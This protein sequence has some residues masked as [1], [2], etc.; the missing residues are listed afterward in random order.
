M[1][2]EKAYR[3][4]KINDAAY[5]AARKTMKEAD[6][7]FDVAFEKESANGSAEKFRL[8][9]SDGDPSVQI[10]QS[11]EDPSEFEKLK[12]EFLSSHPGMNVNWYAEPVGYEDNDW[13][14]L[15]EMT[16]ETR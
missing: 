10:I 1:E 5:L 16:E 12:K 7:V 8:T 4:R 11:M 15:G 9:P 2:V 6:A 14:D 3:A 13:F